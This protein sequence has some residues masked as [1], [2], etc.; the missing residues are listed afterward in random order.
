MK[1]NFIK[2]KIPS[3]IMDLIVDIYY[4]TRLEP[5]EPISKEENNHVKANLFNIS[6]YP[7]LKEI[8]METAK[9]LHED[10]SQR[11]L[12]AIDWHGIK[13]YGEGSI[14]TIDA[15]NQNQYL[16]GSIIKVDHDAESWPLL[17]KNT[18]NE[19]EKINLEVG[20]IVIFNS[21]DYLSDRDCELKG[22]YSR[23]MSLYYR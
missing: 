14:G 21:K 5:F 13:S 4:L 7:N 18:N 2:T 6:K 22:L 11:K 20:E 3:L 12:Q 15:L 8:L 19:I 23:E 10:F 9:P 17:I 1:T 16:V